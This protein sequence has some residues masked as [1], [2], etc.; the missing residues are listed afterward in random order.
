[1]IIV[2]IIIIIVVLVVVVV[3]KNQLSTYLQHDR[4]KILVSKVKYGSCM[5]K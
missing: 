4:S 1:M 2:I 5:E 3:V